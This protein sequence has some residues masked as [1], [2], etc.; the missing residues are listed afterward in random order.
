[1]II[2]FFFSTRLQKTYYWI[3]K[4]NETLISEKRLPNGL[5]IVFLPLPNCPVVSLHLIYK[6]GSKNEKPQQTGF[7]HL[8]EH[9]MFEGTG[10]LPKGQ[11]DSIS[12]KAGGTN[13]AYTNY[14]WTS[15]IMTL[16]KNQLELAFFLETDRMFNMNPT[17]EAFENQKKVVIE[18]I[19][20]TVLNQ[21]YGR[22]RELLAE[23]AYPKKSGYNWEVHGSS[24]DVAISTLDQA[25]EF[26]N[27]FYS[28]QNA[29]LAIVGDYT[30]DYVF[31]LADEYFSGSKTRSHFP[32][33]NFS[34]VSMGYSS[35]KDNVPYAGTFLSY[36]VPSFLD[37]KSYITDIISAIAGYGKSSI[38]YNSLLY[39]KQC[40]SETAAYPDQR[41]KSS[42]LTFYAIANDDK[43]TPEELNLLLLEEI[44]KLKDYDVIAQ[45]LERTKNQM[46]MQ[47]AN[48]LLSSSSLAESICLNSAFFNNPERTF[49]TIN[50]YNA[51][52]VED[53]LEYVNTY[54]VDNNLVRIDVFNK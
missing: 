44:N 42:L 38:L 1:M 4:L 54:I 24:E 5:N 19:K 21:P 23:T 48:S 10:N 25:R 43:T 26:F 3:T 53:C 13:N 11:F 17:P 20:Q 27:A 12:S 7:A 2:L 50:K 35:Y 28:P 39:K 41:E 45:H 37:D 22:W 52:T 32:E 46:K 8:F 40:V 9:L 16:P 30:A 18:E 36:H 33:N 34:E 47:Y 15:Y 6:T 29:T 49:D 14:D 51:I 31:K